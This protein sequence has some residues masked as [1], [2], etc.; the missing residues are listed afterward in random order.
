MK[1]K[2][3]YAWI[4]VIVWMMIIFYF[5][6]QPAQQ[7][8]ELSTGVT[9]LMTEMINYLIPKLEIDYTSYTFYIRKLAHIFVYFVL[10]CLLIR[11]FER[12]FK[13]TYKQIISAFLICLLFAISDEVH[14]LFVPGRSGEFRD[15]VIDTIGATFGI[16]IYLLRFKIIVMISPK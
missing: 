9:K 10:G 4:P 8:S 15:V 12:R 6:H 11:A 1:R 5:S 3:F 2:W 14:Q 7:S 13:I 16:I